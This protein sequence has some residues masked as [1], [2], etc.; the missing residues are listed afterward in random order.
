MACGFQSY[1]NNINAGG[2]NGVV[3]TITATPLGLTTIYVGMAYKY[4]RDNGFLDGKGSAPAVIELSTGNTVSYKSPTM[5]SGNVF[6]GFGLLS[7]ADVSVCLPVYYDITGFEKEVAGTGDLEA[8]LKLVNPFERRDALLKTAYYLKV[9]FPTGLE[10]RGYFPRHSYYIENDGTD[11][12]SDYFTAGNITASPVMVWTLDLQTVRSSLPLRF[13][14]N[15]GGL[16]NEIDKPNAFIGALGVDYDI[17]SW[18]TLFAEIA[19]ESRLKHYTNQYSLFNLNNDNVWLSPG[20]KINFPNGIKLTGAGDLGISAFTEAN[21]NIYTKDNYQYTTKVMPLLGAQVTVSW[22]GQIKKPDSDNDGI[23]DREDKCPYEAEDIDGFEDENGCPD[24]DN[25]A[26]GVPDEVDS[27]PDEPAECD[28][29]PPK[30]IDGD[31]ITDDTDRCPNKPE[32]KDG[33]EDNDG[34]PDEDND[35]DGIMDSDDKCPDRAE[36]KD[37]FEDDD[38]CPDEDNDGDGVA[39]VND[40]C[41]HKKGPADNNGCPKTKKIKRGRLVLKGVNFRSGKAVLTPNSYRIL[42][43]VAKSLKEWKD[44]KLEIIGYT[45]SRGSYAI[46]K[47]LSQLRANSVRDYLV[48]QGIEPSRLRAIGRGEEN[49]IANNA[50]AE[51]RAANRRVEMNRID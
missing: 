31:G 20:I 50:T 5:M 51:G 8:A 36:D 30:D 22:S 9:T 15:F 3:R 28:G 2:Q 39:D 7:K 25:D 35:R 11:M 41:P 45:D 24:K 18:V 43:E 37:G 23:I 1:G 17:G 33:F 16:I 27:C 21:R 14:I 46:N 32:D 38:G 13:H 4:D 34:C 12:A 44:V 48:R 26:D 49:P 19:G 10:K 47:R 40:K 29:C 42:D 6:V